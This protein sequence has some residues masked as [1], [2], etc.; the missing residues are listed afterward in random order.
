MGMSKLAIISI[1]CTIF[2]NQV[3]AQ[4]NRY[5]VFFDTKFESVYTLD[6]PEA[7]LSE[8]AIERRIKYNIPITLQDLPVNNLHINGVNGIDSVS[9]FYQ[10]KWLNGVLIEA[11]ES[12]ISEIEQLTYVREVQFV[13]PGQRL[14]FEALNEPSTTEYINQTSEIEE[15]TNAAQND[16]IGAGEMHESGFSGKGKMIAVFDAGFIGTNFSP[17]FTRMYE[18]NQVIASWDFVE[19]TDNIYRYD[20]HGTSVL[21]T[22]TAYLDEVFVGVAP[23]AEVILCVTEDVPTEYIIEEYNWLFAAEY[24]DSTG[25]DIINTSLGYNT[26]DDPSMDYSYQDMDGNTAIITRAND[27]AS[28]K[29]I[30]CVVS[31]GN[32]GDDELWGKMV[33]PADADS[34]IAV[35]AVNADEEYQIFSSRGP[36]SDDRI[37]PEVS[38][39]GKGTSLVGW[40]GLLTY[41]SGTSYAA[42]LIAGLAAGVWQAYPYL[43]NME[44]IEL[45]KAGSTQYNNPDTL[46]G[47]GIPDFRAI[48]SEITS[49]DDELTDKGYK[50]YPNPV[51]G[52]RLF[53]ELTSAASVIND[54][55]I[56]IFDVNGSMV[57]S[58]KAEKIKSGGRFE[59]D[60]KKLTSGIYVLHLYSGKDSG[61]VKILIP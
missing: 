51:K 49:L 41:G 33:A 60:L 7:Y 47:Y 3:S 38:A 32:E 28:S 10:T 18:N 36:T 15:L 8:R 22:I 30:L 56:Q 31:V 42:P 21:S 39:L 25:V 55:D 61:K 29:G 5:M 59:L 57:F 24:A 43:N 13:A 12:K 58:H 19:N 40:N 35:G 23:D 6:N 26:F 54:I 16:M 50:I 2:L 37:K 27:I 53:V 14:S 9:V 17:Y 1:M 46:I 11:H 52:Y 48:Q 4:V 45:I 34:V 44:I 20:D